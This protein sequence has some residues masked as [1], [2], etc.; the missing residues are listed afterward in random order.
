MMQRTR[1]R[2][3]DVWRALPY[4]MQLSLQLALAAATFLVLMRAFFSAA[5]AIEHAFTAIGTYMTALTSSE[6]RALAV[7]MQCMKSLDA[8]SSKEYLILG[9]SRA[10][11]MFCMLI[12]SIG[13]N[14]IQCCG[15]NAADHAVVEIRGYNKVTLYDLD[16]KLKHLMKAENM[17][18]GM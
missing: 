11:I 1:A 12:V 6:P 17:Q 9:D 4:A 10:F 14:V 5:T 2:C 18:R 8:L 13:I 16:Q 7:D 15:Y 3:E